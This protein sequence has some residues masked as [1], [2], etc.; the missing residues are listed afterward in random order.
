MVGLGKGDKNIL[1][2]LGRKELFSDEFYFFF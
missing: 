2:V 1:Y